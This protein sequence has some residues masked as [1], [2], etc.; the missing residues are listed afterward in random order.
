MSSTKG[1]HS[2]S[3]HIPGGSGS[4]QTVPEFQ[5]H[6]FRSP[7]SQK[8]HLYLK[9]ARPYFILTHDG[10]T[11]KYG[12][13]GN[14]SRVTLQKGILLGFMRHI[15]SINITIGLLQEVDFEN[16]KVCTASTVVFMYIETHLP[17]VF[18]LII[19]ASEVITPGTLTASMF[20]QLYESL[21]QELQTPATELGPVLKEVNTQEPIPI[22]KTNPTLDPSTI[23]HLQSLAILAKQIPIPPDYIAAFLLHLVL[24]RF[25]SLSQRCISRIGSNGSL[26]PV[27]AKADSFMKS[28]GMCQLTLLGRPG[29]AHSLFTVI[30][31]VK[32]LTGF[33]L[34]DHIDGRLFKYVIANPVSIQDMK[35]PPD[36]SAYYASLMDAFKSDTGLDIPHFGLQDQS[37]S[38]VNSPSLCQVPHEETVDNS[39]EGTHASLKVLPFSNPVFNKHLSC[40]QLAVDTQLST[41]MPTL[42]PLEKALYETHWHSTR[43]LDDMRPQGNKL[44]RIPQ[45]LKWWQLRGNQIARTKTLRYARNLAGGEI[46]PELIIVKKISGK[47][48]KNPAKNIEQSQNNT[49]TRAKTVRPQNSTHGQTSKT[50]QIKAANEQR[51]SKKN[52]TKAVASW[53][54]FY[55]ELCVPCE[56]KRRAIVTLAGFITK[57]K[58]ETVTIEARLFKCCLLFEVWKE[59]YCVSKENKS[60]GYNLVALIFDEAKLI[61]ASSKLTISIKEALDTIFTLLGFTPLPSPK[62]FP[63]LGKV[64]FIL[65]PPIPPKSL[66][67]TEA[68]ENLRLHDFQL[69]H[70][71]P[72]MERNLDP[73]DDPRVKFRPDGWQI[74]VLDALD[75]DKSVFVVAPT[76]SG[77]TFI[78][79]YAMEKVR[80]MKCY[81]HSILNISLTLT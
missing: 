6:E 38:A 58:E 62:S 28:L 7:F 63:S 13:S 18:T 21:S 41:Q 76:S 66:I 26:G 29:Y 27:F 15:M 47:V 59:E 54:S 39:A 42:S 72:Y 46:N 68:G 70:C 60:R 80:G 67:N 4:T 74:K 14:L 23:L 81:S 43:R 11:L 65:P 79:Y 22:A 12:D 9:A 24:K 44:V 1:V 10:S 35:F 57:S 5:V 52:Q 16:S 19:P 75:K 69:Q 32:S 49:N 61:L 48:A 77:K 55:Q 3:G 71:G 40:I 36:I 17:K 31:G 2:T 53:K 20:A 37:S 33:G 50:E 78:A 64:A 51:I 45:K 56:T 73:A 34:S 25:L 8:F 30:S